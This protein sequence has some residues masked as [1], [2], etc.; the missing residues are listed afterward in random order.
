MRLDGAVISGAPCVFAWRAAFPSARY[1]RA[2][3]GHPWLAMGHL[4]HTPKS[5]IAPFSF[6]RPPVQIHVIFTIASLR[7][8]NGSSVWGTQRATEVTVQMPLGA[9]EMALIEDVAV[10]PKS[11]SRYCALTGEEDFLRFSGLI[12]QTKRMLGDRVI[13]NIN[14]TAQGG[15]VAEMLHPLVSYTR[16]LGVNV[17][18]L[19]I[20]GDANFFRVTKRIHHALHGEMGDCSPLAGA[21]KIIYEDNLHANAQELAAYIKRDDVVILHD[22]QCIGLA[23]ILRLQG[24]SIIWRSH[25]GTDR[26]NEQTALGWNFLRNYLDNVDLSIFLRK[27]FVPAMLEDRCVKIIRP[28]IDVFS[29]KNQHLDDATVQAILS[30]AGLLRNSNGLEHSSPEY[31][32]HDGSL[33]IVQSRVRLISESDGFS[34]NT[35]IVLQVSRWDRLK[36]PIGVMHAFTGLGVSGDADLVLAGPDVHGIADDA[37]SIFIFNQTVSA[38]RCLPA[39]KRRHIHL[40]SLPMDDWE[41]NAAIV[42][43]LQ[44]HATIIIQKS[45]QEGFGL[46]VTE[47]MWKG[48]PIIASGVGGILDQ[49]DNEIHG[50]LVHDPLDL[51]SF[52]NA[53]ERLL[54]DKH[55]ASSLGKEARHRVLSE[56]LCMRHLK[57]YAEVFLGLLPHPAEFLSQKVADPANV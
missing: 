53:I 13:W 55:F 30:T 9:G 4:D 25:I 39:T 43:A 50:L 19:A 14:S 11:L 51:F 28:S 7:I 18:W 47:A 40:A 34:R 44:R 57:Q 52:S 24:A 3:A 22:Q 32:R 12:E 36:D 1:G 17:R 45:L 37:E 23:P 35:P 16:G 56:F 42:N 48:K 21:E 33:G 38:W 15:G 29:A 6:A 49:I 46:T 54:K 41:E 8:C 2:N 5:W 10:I 27:E 26:H 20:S 31:R